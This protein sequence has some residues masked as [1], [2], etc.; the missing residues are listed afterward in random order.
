MPNGTGREVVAVSRSGTWRLTVA[1]LF[2]AIGTVAAQAV[3][4]PIGPSRAYPIQATIDV[5][6]GVIL[7]PWP[8]AGLAVLIGILRNL[9]GTGTVFA[10]PGGIFGALLAGY[11]FLWTRSD[12]AAAFGE[13]F[14]TGVIGAIA[15]FPIAR[16]LLGRSVAAFFFVVPFAISSAS[17]AILGFL[18]LK[19]LRSAR[20]LGGRRR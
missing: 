19:A 7:G 9:L 13:V 4:F 6:A 3:S 8:A 12:G 2:L 16:Y 20:L 18:V 1:A 5:L 14:G 10:F 17:G 11:L 15:S